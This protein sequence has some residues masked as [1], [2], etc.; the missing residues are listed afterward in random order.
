M[1][2]LAHRV[3][4][5]AG[6]KDRHHCER[7]RVEGARLLVEPQAQVFGDGTRVRSVVESHHEYTH[8]HHRG[9]RADP[10]EVA[11]GNAVLGSG[12]AHADD[13]LCAE[14]GGQECEPRHPG[15]QGAPRQEEI[16]RRARRSAESPAHAEHHDEVRRHDGVIDP[17]E[18]SVGE[19]Q[20]TGDGSGVRNYTDACTAAG[21]GDACVTLRFVVRDGPIA[22]PRALNNA[23]LAQLG[24]RCIGRLCDTR[25]NRRPPS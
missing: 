25:G 19:G 13:F 8:E 12:R 4:R 18:V 9:D 20:R 5:N 6:G 14:I 17:R 21:R 10:V 2:Q 22:P 24:E 16:V 15:R 7:C 3:H 23:R 1:E 11:R